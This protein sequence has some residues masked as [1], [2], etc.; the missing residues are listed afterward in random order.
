MEWDKTQ[1]CVGTLV[2]TAKI[3]ET[4]NVPQFQE[5]TD[6]DNEDSCTLI[7]AI[8]TG[9]NREIK[10]IISMSCFILVGICT[11]AYVGTEVYARRKENK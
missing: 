3:T 10:T 11:I 9:E 4:E 6:E 5:T 2:N 1:N 7:L 8:R